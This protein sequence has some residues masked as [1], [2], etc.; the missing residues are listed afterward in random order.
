MTDNFIRPEDVKIDIEEV[1]ATLERE[2]RDVYKHE[3]PCCELDVEQAEE[4][5]KALEQQ[6]AEINKHIRMVVKLNDSNLEKQARIKELKKASEWVSFDDR[7]P[8]MG[9]EIVTCSVKFWKPK[10][11]EGE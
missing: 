4:T 10:P 7:L 5:L 3:N 11:P 1:K 2:I 9:V 6:Q 8:I